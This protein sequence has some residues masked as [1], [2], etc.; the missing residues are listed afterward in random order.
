MGNTLHIKGHQIARK[1]FD[2]PQKLWDILEQEL[3]NT[4][5]R[6]TFGNHIE[7]RIGMIN[8]STVGRNAPLEERTKYHAWD[9]VN[10]ERSRIADRINSEL[11][12]VE[13]AVGGEISIDIYPKGWDKSQILKHLPDGAWHFFGD[14]TEPGGNDYAI[15]KKLDKEKHF[16]Y[17]VN[18]YL[19]TE[20]IL[21]TL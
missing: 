6:P 15:A 19:D 7:E 17:S 14:R 1:R 13:A 2:P 5:Y 8:F 20:K 16:V 11:E 3:E 18:S 9:N 10:N 21:R 12:S 4:S